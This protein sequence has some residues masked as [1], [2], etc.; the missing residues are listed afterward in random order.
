[1]N[2]NKHLVVVGKRRYARPAERAEILTAWE[3]SGLSAV[4]FAARHGLDKRSLYRWRGQERRAPLA[5]GA[6]LVEV[7]APAVNR[8]WAAEVMTAVGTVRLS[9]VAAPAWAAAL[10]RELVQC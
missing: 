2:E 4:D 8:G 7:P 5:R 1:M 9:P 10:V 6:S 3:A